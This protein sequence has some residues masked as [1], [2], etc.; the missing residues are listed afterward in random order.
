VIG[1]CAEHGIPTPPEITAYLRGVA[2]R[3]E[4]ARQ[5][6]D[7]RAALPKIMGFPAKKKGPGKPFDPDPAGSDPYDLR[8]LVLFGAELSLGHS[9]AKALGNATVKLPARFA[10]L[11]E[12]SLKKRIAKTAGLEIMPSTAAEWRTKLEARVVGYLDLLHQVYLAHESRET[13]A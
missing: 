13:D 10:S 7:L 8:L 11:D 1:I 5:E 3:M 2:A 6:S 12:R 9:V 4:G